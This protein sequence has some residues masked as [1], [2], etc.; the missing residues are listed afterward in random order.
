[1]QVGDRAVQ[2]E[3]KKDAQ[4]E[5]RRRGDERQPSH[6]PDCSRAGISKLQMDAA[7]ITPA[8]KP[9]SAL[10]TLGSTAFSKTA[11]TPRPGSSPQR[12]SAALAKP[13]MKTFCPSILKDFI[14]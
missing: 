10:C 14:S 5:A 13:R 3:Q 7:V 2:Q 12:G 6:A 9:V 4:P 1:M 8:A 11:R